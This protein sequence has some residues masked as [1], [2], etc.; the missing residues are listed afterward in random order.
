MVVAVPTR[1]SAT[2]GLLAAFDDIL[3]SFL[4]GEKETPV[5]HDG[6]QTMQPEALN[7]RRAPGSGRERAADAG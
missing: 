6:R 2:A 4:T 7:R 3:A 5:T 1:R